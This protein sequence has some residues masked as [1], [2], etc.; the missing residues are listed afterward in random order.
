MK[1]QPSEN[2]RLQAVVFAVRDDPA[3]ELGRRALRE[4]E[5]HGVHARLAG[6]DHNV[7]RVP[8]RGVGA[9][10][11]ECVG[12]HN[13]KLRRHEEE[14][15]ADRGYDDVHVGG[16]DDLPPD[17]GLDRP[18]PEESRVRGA[19]AGQGAG[20]RGGVGGGAQSTTTPT[21]TTTTT[22]TVMSGAYTR[23][24]RA[25]DALRTHLVDVATQVNNNS[26]NNT[27]K[28]L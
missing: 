19:G 12:R 13:G 16:V 7:P 24:T 28:L 17:G 23:L 3:D 4:Q 22:T 10:A 18:A 25:T 26:S 5:E 11:H 14:G 15:V 27:G 8:G 6:A 1:T 21:T 9:Q 20:W 2:S